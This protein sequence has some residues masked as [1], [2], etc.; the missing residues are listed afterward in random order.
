MTLTIRRV[1]SADGLGSVSWFPVVAP[2]NYNNLSV[3]NR[4]AADGLWI[5]TDPNDAATEL[6]VP[7]GAEQ[8][9]SVPVTSYFDPLVRTRDPYHFPSGLT[10]LYLKTVSGSGPVILC[11]L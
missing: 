9:F 6:F 10:A 11:W 7:A 2:Q 4:E 5:C 8:S 1:G 3:S